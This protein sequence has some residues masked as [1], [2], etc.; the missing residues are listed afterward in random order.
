MKTIPK[1]SLL[2]SLA[3]VATGMFPQGAKAAEKLATEKAT[4]E[5]APL[6]VKGADPLTRDMFVFKQGAETLEPKS[7]TV[8]NPRELL[9]QWP[10]S[11]RWAELHVCKRT[12]RNFPSGKPRLSPKIQVLSS[13]YSTSRNFT[14]EKKE[15]LKTLCGLLGG[16]SWFYPD[17]RAFRFGR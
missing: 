12:S 4:Q 14:P 16:E 15:S 11:G 1:F 6:V 8:F 9:A 3:V 13:S 5:I 17:E 10:S 2:A 7:S